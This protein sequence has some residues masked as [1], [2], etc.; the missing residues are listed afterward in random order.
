MAINES[1]WEWYGKPGHFIQSHLCVFHL[2]TRVGGYLISTVGDL[3]EGSKEEKP[4]GGG[5]EPYE[6]YV[7]R[8]GRWSRCDCGCGMPRPYRMAEIEGTRVM[9]A[10]QAND[11]HME[12][13]RKYAAL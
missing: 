3:R 7:F 4:L 12:M 6:T 5:P 13:C 9:T 10:K 8:L 1:E 2:C 11:K